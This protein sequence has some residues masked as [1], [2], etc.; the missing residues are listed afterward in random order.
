MVDKRSLLF[1]KIVH[2]DEVKGMG[3]AE[4]DTVRISLAEV[5]LPDSPFLRGEGNAPKRADLKAHFASHA[6]NLIHHHRVRLD[7]PPQCTAGADLKADGCFTLGTDERSNPLS[8]RENMDPDARRIVLEI[9]CPHKGT[10]ILAVPASNA[11]FQIDGKDL[12][13]LSQTNYRVT[14]RVFLS[15]PA[16]SESE[17]QQKSTFMVRE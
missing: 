1:W 6:P 7:I 16:T 15:S 17:W 2:F 10:G 5:T 12:H 8:L 4:L 3:H 14:V 9:S 13:P 11:T